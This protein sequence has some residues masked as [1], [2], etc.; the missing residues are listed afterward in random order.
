MLF[1]CQIW[2]T[3]RG[4]RLVASIGGTAETD[5][6]AMKYEDGSRDKRARMAITRAELKRIIKFQTEL[7]NEDPAKYVAELPWMVMIY[8]EDRRGFSP[9]TASASLAVASL[10]ATHRRPTV[11]YIWKLMHDTHNMPRILTGWSPVN[12]PGLVSL[13]H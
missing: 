5:I 11:D 4:F 7:Y 8:F 9:E 3:L 13:L 2:A 10:L 12:D 1:D 6:A